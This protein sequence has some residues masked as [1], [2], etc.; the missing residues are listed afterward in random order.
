MHEQLAKMQSDTSGFVLSPAESESIADTASLATRMVCTT[1]ALFKL[2]ASLPKMR[3]RRQ[4]VKAAK[5]FQQEFV[6][7][8]SK[9]PAS[10]QKVLDSFIAGKGGAVD[11]PKV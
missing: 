10:M 7:K 9:L 2:G 1:Y 6:L 11:P 4:Q 5:A 3:V 8:G